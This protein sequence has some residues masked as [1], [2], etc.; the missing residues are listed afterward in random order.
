MVRPRR[1]RRAPL[2]AARDSRAAILR[3]AD[4]EFSDR[5]YDAARVDRIA[6]AACLNKAML[7]YHFGSKRNLYLEVLRDVFKAVAARA[8]AIAD[9]PGTALDKLD[10][11]IATIVEE[12][13]ARPW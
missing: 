8:R 2:R 9:G 11:W 3:A 1:P 5:G 6:A 10:A 12:A 4:D 7:Y 13:G